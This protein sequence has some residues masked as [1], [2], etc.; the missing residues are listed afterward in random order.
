MFFF[1]FEDLKF[2]FR[3]TIDGLVKILWLEIFFV[4]VDYHSICMRRNL[5][6]Y[7]LL[8]FD[9]FYVWPGANL[10]CHTNL[11]GFVSYREA[12]SLGW[13]SILFSR[14]MR[15]GIPLYGYK[16]IIIN[17]FYLNN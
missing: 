17:I 15:S 5:T 14:G 8:R 4:I 13:N 6:S 16:D 2:I 9:I 7:V 11:I 10:A 1:L 3:R 12:N